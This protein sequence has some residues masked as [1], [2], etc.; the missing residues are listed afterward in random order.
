MKNNKFQHFN[1]SVLSGM[2]IMVSFTDF[3]SNINPLLLI[4][5]NIH[6]HEYFVRRLFKYF[7]GNVMV[8]VCE[9]RYKSFHFKNDN[10]R[11]Y[12]GVD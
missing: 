1:G 6:S 11:T 7:L 10:K 3:N 12:G 9:R 5:C 4:L 8:V 2:C